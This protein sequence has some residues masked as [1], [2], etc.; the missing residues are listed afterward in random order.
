MANEMMGIPEIEVP[1][2]TFD[3]LLHIK[4]VSMEQQELFQKILVRSFERLAANIHPSR[5]DGG[6]S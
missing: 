1:E 3:G 5:K 2:R 4:P 6:D